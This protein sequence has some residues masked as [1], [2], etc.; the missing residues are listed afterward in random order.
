[1]LYLKKENQLGDFKTLIQNHF[2]LISPLSHI[3]S[4]IL[5]LWFVTY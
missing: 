1:M 2:R 3:H 4:N 5:K